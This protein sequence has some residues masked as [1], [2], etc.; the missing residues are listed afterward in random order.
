MVIAVGLSLALGWEKPVW[1]MFA[2]IYCTLGDKGES[3]HKG[4]M[5]ILATFM[6]GSLSLVFIALFYGQRWGFAVAVACWIT[7]CAYKMQNNRRYYFWFVGGWMTI[8][9]PI[10]SAG[11]FELAFE[12][13]MLRLQETIL[14]VLVYTV[15]A[16][17]LLPDRRQRNFMDELHD[18]LIN[19]QQVLADLA[20]YRGGVDAADNEK[21]ALELRRQVLALHT[22]F[23]NRIDTG[24]I[25][26]FEIQNNRNAWRRAVDE[27]TM[28]VKKLDSLSITIKALEGKHPFTTQPEFVAVVREVERRLGETVALLAGAQTME[29]PRAVKI[30][31]AEVFHEGDDPFEFGNTLINL[32]V[33]AEIERRSANL[34]YAVGQARGIINRQEY[35]NEEQPFHSALLRSVFPDPE[36]LALALRA[37]LTFLLAFMIYIFVP[38]YSK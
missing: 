6:G 3:F 31:G 9:M 7:L 12:I 18:Q 20:A 13:L 23:H 29:P 16:N 10:Y 21:T 34:L 38:D 26:S 22:N 19:L 17:V 4:T 5:R 30:A 8:L 33:L 27:F 24:V 37:T 15:V 14:G 35:G 32:E 11:H 36:K 28:L 25:E 2:V 1:A